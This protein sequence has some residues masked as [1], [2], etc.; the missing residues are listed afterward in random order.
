MKP[1][2]LFTENALP[3]ILKALKIS[4]KDGFVTA[5]NGDKIDMKKII[6][7]KKSVGIIVEK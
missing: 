7:F 4:F 3:L 5:P 1:K 6:G 2:L